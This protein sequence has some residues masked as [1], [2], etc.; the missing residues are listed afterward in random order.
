[1]VTTDGTVL[2]TF[3]YLIY[4]K[5]GRDDFTKIDIAIQK[6]SI[7]I[8]LFELYIFENIYLLEYYSLLILGYFDVGYFADFILIRQ[9]NKEIDHHSD[10]SNHSFKIQNGGRT[11]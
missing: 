7:N 9:H 1:M 10:Y 3:L 5:N 11:S 2:L 4:F 8:G 6:T